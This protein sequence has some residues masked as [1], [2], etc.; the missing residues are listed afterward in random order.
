[1]FIWYFI[2]AILSQNSYQKQ[3]GGGG[4]RK[5][6]KRRDGHIVGGGEWGGVSI[7]GGPNLLHTM[8]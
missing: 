4:V 6:I 7:E 5:K 1:M 8:H 3:G 2:D